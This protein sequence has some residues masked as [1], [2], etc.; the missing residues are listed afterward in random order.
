[1]TLFVIWTIILCANACT[2]FQKKNAPIC[3]SVHFDY[4]DNFNDHNARQML[5]FYCLCVDEKLCN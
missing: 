4:S 3:D 5:L 2:T 1:L